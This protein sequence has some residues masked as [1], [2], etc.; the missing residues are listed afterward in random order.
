MNFL[1]NLVHRSRGLHLASDYE[2][3]T[4]SKPFLWLLVVAWLKMAWC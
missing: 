2:I 3:S 4:F 1:N